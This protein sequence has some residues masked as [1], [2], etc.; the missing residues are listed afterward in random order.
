MTWGT[1]LD[2]ANSCETFSRNAAREQMRLHYV[3][4]DRIRFK[5]RNAPPPLDVMLELRPIVVAGRCAS[6][7]CSMQSN[8]EATYFKP[9]RFP[10]RDERFSSREST[11]L[12]RLKRGIEC[13]FN[14]KPLEVLDHDIAKF[15]LRTRRCCVELCHSTYK[16]PVR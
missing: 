10:K 4:I 8:L 11:T 15:M 12:S 1:V 5:E 14:G 9:D 13:A 3:T 16:R 6:T 2:S 7:D